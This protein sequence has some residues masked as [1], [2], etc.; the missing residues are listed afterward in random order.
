M[1]AHAR[2][3]KRLPTNSDQSLADF[4]RL[5][6]LL[7]LPLITV[8][9]Q[10]FAKLKQQQ[11]DETKARLDSRVKGINNGHD[12]EWVSFCVFPLRDIERCFP[13]LSDRTSK[14]SNDKVHYV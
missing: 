13:L 2:Q 10:E 9:L 6:P 1:L 12:A 14:R 4:S 3:E 5:R 11:Y 7:S 8:V